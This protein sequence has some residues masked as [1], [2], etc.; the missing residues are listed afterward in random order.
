MNHGAHRAGRKNEKQ[1]TRMWQ[2]RVLSLKVLL[3]MM[4]MV[5]MGNAHADAHSL[6][7]SADA[8]RKERHAAFVDNRENTQAVLSSTQERTR[9]CCPRQQRLAPSSHNIVQNGSTLGHRLL[10]YYQK[11]VYRHYRRHAGSVSRPIIDE[12]QCDHYVLTLRHLLC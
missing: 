2:K 7:G 6:R 4:I 9:L 5:V 1:N 8:Q 11:A 3:L 10:F 12:P